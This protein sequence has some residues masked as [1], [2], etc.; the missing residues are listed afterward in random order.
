MQINDT[1]TQIF[2]DADGWRAAKLLHHINGRAYPTTD[3][4]AMKLG[5]TLKVRFIGSS[6]GFIHPMHIHGG[7]FEVVAIDGQT[8]DRSARYFADTVNVAPE[9]R[10]DVIWKA[11]AG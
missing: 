6:N 11:R 4:I 2:G 7:P 5:E 10:Y 8:V 3:T 1:G 9:Q